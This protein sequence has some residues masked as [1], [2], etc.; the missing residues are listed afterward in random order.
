MAFNNK[1]KYNEYMKEYMLK[2]YH[3]R[4]AKAVEL[5]G[6]RCQKC[7]ALSSLEIDHIRP[8]SKT[9]DL[10]RLWSIAENKYLKELKKCQLLCD[11]C[12]N[13]KSIIDHGHK[14]AK[15]T[16]GT[17]SAYRYCKC[18]LCRQAKRD[19]YQTYKNEHNARRRAKRAI[20]KAKRKL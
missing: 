5:L 7:G 17:I 11:E 15:G 4:R 1:E 14:K 18:D 20:E 16:H 8:K 12:H 3:Q 13:N 10:G 9:F 19:W 6:G 2:R